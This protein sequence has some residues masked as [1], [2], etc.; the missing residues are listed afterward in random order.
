[1]NL[2]HDGLSLWYD[3]PDAPA[4]GD[5]GAVPRR[6]AALVIGVKPANPTNAVSV[7]YRV[8]GGIVQTTPAR[9][10]RTDYQRQVQYF[11]VAFP[12]FPSG[13]LVEYAPM[14]SVGGRQV[15][16]PSAASNV[17]PS[18]FR[19]EDQAAPAPWPTPAPTVRGQRFDPGLGF[20]ASVALTFDTP[21]FI[22]ETADGV[23]I[24]FFVREGS[25]V[26]EGVR[27]KVLEGSSD[28]MLVRRD[29]MALTRIRGAFI[30]DDGALIDIESGGYV[31]FGPEGYRR[32]L[33]NNLPD[34][35][36]LFVTPLVS[37]RHPR[38]RWLSRIQCLGVGQTHLDA[39]QVSYQLYAVSPHHLT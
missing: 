5:S 38:Y 7:R 17:F 19:L 8:D 3:T 31:D 6:G 33:A 37:T 25:V 39:Q 24:N 34:Q 29:G 14:M 35:A 11:A 30:L 18:K 16:S 22:G 15:P 1:M 21:Q 10:L 13:H 23:R 20:V 26:G 2:T 28:H 4:P 36:P 27:G 12:A 9:E 32:A